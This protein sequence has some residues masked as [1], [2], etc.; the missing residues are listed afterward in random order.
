L[1]CSC[2]A[3]V[4]SFFSQREEVKGILLIH[5]KGDRNK[6]TALEL[7]KPKV[8]KSADLRSFFTIQALSCDIVLW[9]RNQEVAAVCDVTSSCFFKLLSFG[10]MGARTGGSCCYH[11]ISS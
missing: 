1:A 3:F 5:A 9:G 8:P 11:L 4:S 2:L 6:I 7:H 10:F